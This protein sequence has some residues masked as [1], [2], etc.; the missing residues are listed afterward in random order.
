MVRRTQYNVERGAIAV[1][2]RLV[3]LFLY[4]LLAGI[5]WVSSSSGIVAGRALPDL[6][7]SPPNNLAGS[8]RCA[9]DVTPYNLTVERWIVGT[10]DAR[11]SCSWD[12]QEHRPGGDVLYDRASSRTAAATRDRW[13]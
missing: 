10:G 2:F 5:T 4:F 6:F 8:D 3:V 1:R 13:Q 12:V 9:G 7:M 11:A